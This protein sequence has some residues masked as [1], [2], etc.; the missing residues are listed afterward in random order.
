MK[1]TIKNKIKFIIIV[2]SLLIFLSGILLV[3]Y[4]KKLENDLK[5]FIEIS[6]FK[7]NILHLDKIEK[8]ILIPGNDI[9]LK[10]KKNEINSNFNK[11]YEKSKNNISFLKE[12]DII[13]SYNLQKHLIILEKELNNYND[14]FSQLK[15]KLKRKGNEDYGIVGK[16]YHNNENL[17]KQEKKIESVDFL[18]NIIELKNITRDYLFKN[19]IKYKDDFLIEYR[20]IIMKLQKTEPTI[21]IN[22]FY[23]ILD[24]YKKN[25]VELVNIN[26]EIGINY[27]Y[28]LLLNLQYSYKR[29]EIEI[30]KLNEKTEK[31]YETRIKYN[32]FTILFLTVVI[33][34]LFTIFSYKISK[35]LLK[36]LNNLKKY[37][38]Q[39][40][41]G[42][43]PEKI[44]IKSKNEISEIF[45]YVNLLITNLKQTKIF[46]QEVGKGNFETKINVFNNES[47][48]GFSLI[49]MRIEL[50]KIAEERKIKEEEDE[51]RNWQNRTITK[52]NDI[53]RKNGN[54]ISEIGYRVLKH[55]IDYVDASQGALFITNDENKNLDLIS[56]YAYNRRKYISKVV[57]YGE[58]L[59]GRCAL[60]KKT[61]NMT[62]IPEGEFEISSGLG[63][64]K[65]ETML[66]IPLILNDDFMGIIEIASLQKI[67][68]YKIEL[69]EKIAESMASF[70]LNHKINEKTNKLLLETQGQSRELLEKEEEMRQ[71][72]EELQA[73]QEEAARHQAEATGFVDSV[74]HAIIRA[75]YNIDGNMEYANT[76]FIRT[77]GYSVA[78]MEG[79]H[80]STL[81]DKKNINIFLKEWK[82]LIKGG[83][84]I[85]REIRFNTKYGNRWILSTYTSIKD[86]RGKI[87]KILFLGT[88]VEEAKRKNLDFR[89]EVNA[90]NNSVIKIEYKMNGKIIETNENFRKFT[91]FSKDDLKNKNIFF[92]ILKEDLSEFQVTWNKIISGE[93][94]Q[95][96][97]KR[98]NKKGE[99]IWVQGT[100]SAVE[101][102]DGEIYKVIFIAYNITIRK[103][104][105]RKTL[106]LTE[107]LKNK[108]TDLEKNIKSLELIQRNLTKKEL[109]MNEQIVAINEVN[110]LLEID[111]DGKILEANE[112]FCDLFGFLRMDI[113]DKNH[114]ILMPLEEK[115][116]L[117]YK[118]FV[119]DLKDGKSKTGEFKRLSRD[120]K[121][122]YLQG[123]YCPIFDNENKVRKI[124]FLSFNI[125]ETKKQQSEIIGQLDAINKTNILIE[126]NLEGYIT[127]INEIFTSLFMYSKEETIEKHHNILLTEEDKNLKKYENF[128]IDLKNGYIKKGEFVRRAKNGKIIFLSSTFYPML[129]QEQKPYKIIELSFDIS[130]IKEQEE[131]LKMQTE[132]LA[133]SEEELRQNMEELQATQ[134]DMLRK[135]KEVERNNMKLKASSEILKKT[136]TKQRASQTKYKSLVKGINEIG[137]IATL[138][139]ERKFI[140]INKNLTNFLKLERTQIIGENYEKIFHE[141]KDEFLK[142]F[143]NIANGKTQKRENILRNSEKILFLQE[144]FI[145]VFSSMNKIEKIFIISIDIS[146]IKEQEASL[147]IQKEELT[148][149]EEELRQNMEELQATQEDM[150]KKVE[151]IEI[152]DN[153]LK[154]SA[155][156]LKKSILKQNEAQTEYKTLMKG[157]N[158]IGFIAYLNLERKF[159]DVNK[160]FTNFLNI[161]KTQ[162]IGENYEKIFFNKKEE[163][164]KIFENILNGEIQ[165]RKNHLEIK[166][167]K[168]N[169]KENFIPIFSKR[170]KIS[171]IFLMITEI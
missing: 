70:I 48:L 105:E 34:I 169:F 135:H 136:M 68:N 22:K 29:I 23:K 149:S 88:D 38:F 163:F 30:E 71:N 108:E 55:I 43:I 24:I 66:F 98:R 21:A 81:V 59:V 125:T 53:L 131:A 147:K 83:K 50:L 126:Y 49:N 160:N 62:N 89:G 41:D 67:E 57:E 138:N 101:N 139:L 128:W 36:I 74:N 162:I 137:Y 27:Q 112:L 73:T 39:L 10:D 63:K 142:I 78:E 65:P 91:K 60:E 166:N 124:L 17:R 4:V 158:E 19:N 99:V 31:N 170:N 90:I 51:K 110:L 120:R 171:K 44:F 45:K 33:I 80:V 156:I 129:N 14:Y 7:E 102:F 144:N 133:A 82:N 3:F 113:I 20:T 93:F 127:K 161:E 109:E 37:I 58:G 42:K 9:F 140:D 118:N 15:Y 2:I 46:V 150:L 145:P 32:Y 25:F 94:I 106:E 95:G 130:Q 114:K 100:Y 8:E 85:E 86:I 16:L 148:E 123:T 76:K 103:N 155:Q 54:D 159:S 52:F 47:D 96:E 165:T 77:M 1:L 79:D 72:M 168:I 151:K 141:K 146:K 107:K 143:E 152:R 157:I 26:N 116:S 121:N 154:V 6:F 18:G 56:V 104:A 92:F 40:S 12:S 84:H 75:D 11:F 122:I 87:M 164:S 111:L 5:T 132:E 119:K 64:F 13:E 153:K 69:T 61:I 35:D 134:E 167:K 115:N 28:G 97:F 117:D